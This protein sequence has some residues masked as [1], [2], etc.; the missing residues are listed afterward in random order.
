MSTSAF[1]QVHS[2]PT[3]VAE[4]YAR[5]EP[6]WSGVYNAVS[7]SV[8][9]RQGRTNCETRLFNDVWRYLTGSWV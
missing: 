4:G 5:V 9:P 8:G 2:E 1:V 7:Y 6:I 3:E